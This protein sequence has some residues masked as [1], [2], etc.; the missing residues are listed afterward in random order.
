MKLRDSKIIIALDFSDPSLAWNFID[1]LD[2]SMCRLKIGKEMFTLLGPS[3][4]EKIIKKGFDVFLDLKYHDIPNT[5]AKAS[6]VCAEMGVWMINLHCIGGRK[7]M[8][9]TMNH[10]GKRTHRPLVTGVT[11]LTSLDLPQM[12]EL[13]IKGSTDDFVSNM[14]SLAASCG[15]DGV[16]CSPIEAPRLRNE[17]ENKFLLITPG[18]RPTLS[19]KNDQSRTMTPSE[20]ISAGAD[21]LVIG[22]PITQA[23]NPRKAL[24]DIFTEINQNSN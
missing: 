6:E 21:F 8:E 17:H 10:L 18:I 22:R 15:L 3:F 14:S 13:G 9:H 16:V 11:L 7:M 5:V 24:E 20:A 19:D 1:Q 2:H 4:V 12:N 23:N